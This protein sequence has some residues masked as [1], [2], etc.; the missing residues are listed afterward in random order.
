[1]LRA[2][3]LATLLVAIALP[4]SADQRVVEKH[5]VDA[6][7]TPHISVKIGPSPAAR[8][9]ASQLEVDVRA[10]HRKA[11]VH[12]TSDWDEQIVAAAEKYKL[13]HELV[14]AIIVAES[15]FEPTAVSRVGA[16][17]L[18]QLMPRTAD[19]MYVDDAFDPVQNIHGGARYLRV[20]ANMFDGD[21]V[22][23]IA[24]YNAGP[25]AVKKAKGVPGYA[26]TQ[27]YVRKVVQLYR[28]YRGLGA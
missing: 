2:V 10:T 6:D 26:E 3:A 25:E 20:L 1:M 5:W 14:R 17:G 13:P 18:M 22:K 4:A 24:A 8:A 12:E 15:N 27:A 19:E 9:R 7:G 11:K 28:T 16:Q 23:T 21:I